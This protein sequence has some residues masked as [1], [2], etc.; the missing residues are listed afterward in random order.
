LQKG[1]E[2]KKKMR[3]SKEQCEAEGGEWIEAYTKDDGT[4][5]RGFCRKSSIVPFKNTLKKSEVEKYKPFNTNIENF[6]MDNSGKIYKLPRNNLTGIK[7]ISGD[8]K[9]ENRVIRSDVRKQDFEDIPYQSQRIEKD[10]EK[11]ANESE[12]LFATQQ[13]KAREAYSHQVRKIATREAKEKK[14]ELKN[15]Q[16][17]YK[18]T[19][20]LNKREKKLEKGKEKLDE[21]TKS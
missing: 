19:K 10:A 20:K 5:V 4:H 14:H 2:G 7:H 3:M 8:I 11:S 12:K 1:E 16:K 13:V 21:I 9:N 18:K 17:T 6:N 15:V